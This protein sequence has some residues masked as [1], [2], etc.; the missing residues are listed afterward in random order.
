MGTD[1]LHRI[2][3]SQCEDKLSQH[4]FSAT[5]LAHLNDALDI[6]GTKVLDGKGG[7]SVKCY[8]CVEAGKRAGFKCRFC[9]KWLPGW[10]FAR[11][12]HAHAFRQSYSLPVS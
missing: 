7:V 8:R 11:S 9:N 2:I 4:L 12:Q 10:Q 1:K 5:Q 6:Q 3:C